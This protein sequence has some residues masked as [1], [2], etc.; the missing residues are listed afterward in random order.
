MDLKKMWMDVWV[1]AKFEA[2]PGRGN[3]KKCSQ[4][5]WLTLQQGFQLLILTIQSQASGRQDSTSCR[6][7]SCYSSARLHVLRSQRRTLERRKGRDHPQGLPS[8]LSTIVMISARLNN[9][10]GAHLWWLHFVGLLCFYRKV[11]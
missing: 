8:H 6:S 2:V 3:H 7:S 1:G 11:H 4:R 10:R 9:H 5:A